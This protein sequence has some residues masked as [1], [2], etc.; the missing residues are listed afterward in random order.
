MKNYL[1]I[2][3]ARSH[4]WTSSGSHY[5]LTN[6]F[7]EAENENDAIQ[8]IIDKEVKD[9][10]DDNDD[11]DEIEL[12]IRHCKQDFISVVEVVSPKVYVS[13]K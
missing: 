3:D 4:D 13:R 8:K 12:F 10:F 11:P 2:F 1:V 6:S 5:V 9:N 7:V